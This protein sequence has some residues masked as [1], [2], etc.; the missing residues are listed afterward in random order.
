M[1]TK[2]EYIP[3]VGDKV[4]ILPGNR[5]G[6]ILGFGRHCSN[7]NRWANISFNRRDIKECPDVEELVWDSARDLWVLW[8][9]EDCDEGD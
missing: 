8:K 5:T 7:C 2:T 1:K 3:E 9:E 6:V 4:L